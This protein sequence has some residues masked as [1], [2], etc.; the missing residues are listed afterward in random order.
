MPNR[1]IRAGIISSDRVNCLDHAAEVFYRRLLNMIDD[2]GLYDARP[3]ILR[4]TLYPLRIDR[5]RE[6]DISRWLTNCQTAGL[7]L[8]YEA[9]SKP[10]LK[11]LNTQWESRS[12]PKY[13]QPPKTENACAQLQAE[14]TEHKQLSPY[15]YSDSD[16]DS[17]SNLESLSAKNS[18]DSLTDYNLS[19]AIAEAMGMKVIPDGKPGEKLR[20]I[21]EDF[22]L[23]GINPVDV[24]EFAADWYARKMKAGRPNSVLLPDYLATDLPGWVKAKRL[25]VVGSVATDARKFKCDRCQDT[26]SVTVKAETGVRYVDCPQCQSGENQ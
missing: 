13:P 3:S 11:V 22:R 16:S 6:A 25:R 14:N 7:I 19:D 8:L 21:A 1:I 10:Y 2:H 20:A 24:S 18:N 26:T 4:A 17:L 23:A 9:E 12:K 15:S 5:V